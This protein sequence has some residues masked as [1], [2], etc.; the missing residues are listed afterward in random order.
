MSFGCKDIKNPPNN[1]ITGDFSRNFFSKKEGVFAPNNFAVLLPPSPSSLKSEKRTQTAKQRNIHNKRTYKKN[2]LFYFLNIVTFPSITHFALF[3]A[4][5]FFFF[6]LY[7]LFAFYLF[8]SFLF[9]LR[10]YINNIKK[11]LCIIK[12]L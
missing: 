4:F 5:L 10:K 7:F 1:K 3:L 2:I 8:I 6:F 9:S 11:Y 12:R